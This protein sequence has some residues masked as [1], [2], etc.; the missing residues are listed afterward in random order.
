MSRHRNIRGRTFS[1]DDDYQDDDPW[2]S[3][4]EY[5]M[6]PNSQSYMYNRSQQ[7]TIADNF[8]DLGGSQQQEQRQQQIEKW[9]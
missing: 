8:F 7:S 6:S 9:Q 5:A 2:D 3:G 1:Y 4:S